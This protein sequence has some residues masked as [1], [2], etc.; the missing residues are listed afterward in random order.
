VTYPFQGINGIRVNR[1]T[2]GQRTW[3]IN[4]DG[5]A[6]YGLYPDWIQ[7]LAKVAGSEGRAIT[8]DMS[9]GPEAYLQMWERAEGILPDSCRNPELRQRLTKVERL[10]RPG[11]GT[12]AVMRAVGQ[13]YTRLGRTFGFCAKTKGH[14]SV[15][16]RVLFSRGGKVLAL[17]RGH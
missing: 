17:R 10:I 3:D 13:P 16:L 2:A 4:T 15:K 8:D 12:R 11:M 14:P 9:R 1:Q 7:D 6:Q 5:V